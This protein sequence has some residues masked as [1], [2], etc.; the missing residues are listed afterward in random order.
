[1]VEIFFFKA[2]TNCR[3]HIVDNLHYT[4]LNNNNG[5]ASGNKVIREDQA[6]NRKN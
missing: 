1:M 5:L 6:Q 2:Q 4:D 3:D